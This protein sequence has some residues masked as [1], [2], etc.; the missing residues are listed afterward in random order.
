MWRAIGLGLVLGAIGLAC[1][2]APTPG[3]GGSTTTTTIPSG[4]VE[5]FTVVFIGD[6]EMR[7]RGNTPAEVAQYVSAIVDYNDS[8]VAY[9]DYGGGDQ[10]RIEPEL[11]MLGG[12]ISDDRH[13]SIAEDIP[14]FQEFYANGIP[15]IAGFG[16]HD[17]E[18]DQ[19]NDG[20][21]YSV[22]GHLSN[23]STK[24]F[25][26]ET[27]VRSAQ[28]SSDFSY[29]AMSPTSTFGPVTYHATYRGV[30]IV[31][32]NTFL[33]QPSYY[34]PEGWPVS[35]NLEGGGAGC[36]I[37]ASAE[38]QIAAMEAKL[39]GDRSNPVLFFQHY[40]LST[41]DR[42]WDDFGSSGTTLQQRKDRLKSMIAAEDDAIL[43]AGHQHVAYTAT[44]PIGADTVTEYVAPYFGGVNDADPTK[45]GGFLAILVSPTEGILEVATIP[46]GG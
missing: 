46:A 17:W 19:W 38:G 31:N 43:L 5:P 4:P 24:A 9:F 39:A 6:S 8:T 13:T 27:Y 2:P 7:M 32:F 41:T 23:E 25:T 36:Q 29:T 30:E 15:F 20:P 37:Y 14:V 34:Y 10:Y 11:V 45:G 22:A 40:P 42:W 3:G 16:N 12:D 44:H 28:A 26:R 1:T 35:C 18:P 21:G 33:Y